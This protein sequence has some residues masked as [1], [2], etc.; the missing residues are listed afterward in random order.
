M[1]PI[2]KLFSNYKADLCFPKRGVRIMSNSTRCPACQ[3]ELKSS[4]GY[5]RC[6]ECNQPL[7]EKAASRDQSLASKMQGIFSRLEGQII[8]INH[9]TPNEYA[10]AQIVKAGDDYF[11]IRSGGLYLH[12]PYL[13]VMK[14]QESKE[15]IK[16]HILSQ[17]EYNTL[18]TIEHM[19]IYKGA[20]GVALPV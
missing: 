3:A 9:T 5:V 18:I 13:R 10:K 11:S 6:P 4:L 7:N 19:I 16:P 8:G 1:L 17:E 20:V 12:I 15:W 14:I 2:K